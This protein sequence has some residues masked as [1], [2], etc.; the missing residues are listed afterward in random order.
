MCINCFA[1]D[2]ITNH[3]FKYLFAEYLYNWFQAFIMICNRIDL[4]E[5]Y[6]WKT[7]TNQITQTA[8]LIFNGCE[9]RKQEGKNVENFNAMGEAYL[10]LFVN[11]RD[12][13]RIRMATLDN[14]MRPKQSEYKLWTWLPEFI[15]PW[16]ILGG[17]RLWISRCWLWPPNSHSI[18]LPGPY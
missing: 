13:N 2:S 9:N 7:R 6:T 15:W 4:Y 10:W 8:P 16:S 5:A 17:G 18:G 11:P 14:R 12:G 1:S 3:V